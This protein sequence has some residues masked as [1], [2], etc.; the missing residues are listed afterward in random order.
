MPK[1]RQEENGW[2]HIDW[3]LRN[4]T[5]NMLDW[6]WS[7]LEKTFFLWNPKDHHGFKWVIQPS[8]DQ[9]IGCIHQT[10]QGLEPPG[11]DI[12]QAMGLKYFDVSIMPENMAD[13][14]IY[15]HV[16]LVGGVK[17]RQS[18]DP[19]SSVASFRLHQYQSSD[20]GVIG[21]SSAITPNIPDVKEEL[22]R[23]LEWTEHAIGELGNFEIFLS[24][25]YRCWSVVENPDLNVFHSLKILKTQTG[26]RYANSIPASSIIWK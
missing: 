18:D 20:E 3:T 8:K 26:I 5:P 14:V 23:N 4:I 25:M 21:I 12:N 7:N 22:D 15:D 13:V 19:L 16:C 10:L 9:F 6:H 11:F 1:V 2:T 17:E 24:D